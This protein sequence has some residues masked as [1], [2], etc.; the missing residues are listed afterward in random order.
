MS[1]PRV[2]TVCV[3]TYGDY[4][5]FYERCL[6]SVLAHTP[7]DAVELRLGFNAAPASFHFALGRLCPDGRGPRRALLPGGVERFHWEGPGG[8]PVTAWRSALNLYKEPMSRLM[9]HDAA[10]ETEYAIWLDDD[11]FV[12]AG[13][14]E[15]LVPIME[16]R[17]DYIGQSWWV[18]YLPGQ[19]E[20]IQ[21][22]PW[23]RGAPFEQRAG[24]P[25]VNFM[26]GGFIVVRSACLREADFPD[27]ATRWKGRGLQQYG[28]DTLLGEIARQLGWRRATHSEHV[29]VNVDL[30]GKHPAPRRGGTGRQFGSDVDVAVR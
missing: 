3:L 7:A 28:G 1:S 21:A 18:T 11:S 13:W 26:T 16:Q 10:L 22:Q 12:E 8:M 23:Y 20:M 29:H 2:A 14:W 17:L 6:E 30:N 4:P 15:A 24:K 5:D 9:F 25:G 19:L 27:T